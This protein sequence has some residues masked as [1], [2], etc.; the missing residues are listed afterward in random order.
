MGQHHGIDD[1]VNERDT[2]TPAWSF[3]PPRKLTYTRPNTIPG[4][5]PATLLVEEADV[6]PTNCELVLL[7][8]RA[9]VLTAPQ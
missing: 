6:R 1:G 9:E 2:P 3:L 7:A 4:V 8:A 5:A